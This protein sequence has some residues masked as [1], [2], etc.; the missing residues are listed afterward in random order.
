MKIWFV[1]HFICSQIRIAKE[2]KQRQ[3]QFKTW[4]LRPYSFLYLPQVLRL[5]QHNTATTRKSASPAI[6]TRMAAWTGWVPRFALTAIWTLLT[7]PRNHLH[8]H[9]HQHNTATTRKS[10][11]RATII[12]SAA[13]TGV[14]PRFVLTAIWTLLTVPESQSINSAHRKLHRAPTGE[15]LRPQ[16]NVC[17]AATTTSGNRGK[18]ISAS[19]RARPLTWIRATVN[20]T[21][22]GCVSSKDRA[23]GFLDQ[24][25][26]K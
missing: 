5:H 13:W 23:K 15:I 3:Q 8:H 4:S 17:L 10:V 24:T 20:G 12:W 2:K 1:C 6:I 22:T 9:L 26:C 11:S 19:K 16:P 14:V 25:F 21:T 7:V 18:R